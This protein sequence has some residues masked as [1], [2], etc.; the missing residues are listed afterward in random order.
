MFHSSRM[1]SY[2]VGT[3]WWSLIV[4]NTLFAYLMRNVKDAFSSSENWKNI[5]YWFAVGTPL[6]GMASVAGEL[7]G[8]VKTNAFAMGQ[9]AC[10][11]ATMSYVWYACVVPLRQSFVLQRKNS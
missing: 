6:K 9:L 4:L 3:L 8:N 10:V 2:I 1:S 11:F 7:D 5:I